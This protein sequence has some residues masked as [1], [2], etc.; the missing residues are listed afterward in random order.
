PALHG[1]VFLAI[2]GQHQRLDKD[3][4]VIAL[5]QANGVDGAKLVQL[6]KSFTISGKVSQARQLVQTYGVDSVP[7]LVVQGSYA[8]DVSMGG[9]DAGTLRVL[10]GLIQKSRA[11]LGGKA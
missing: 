2:H 5:A 3:A 7:R 9:G 4:E 10:D 8:T 1:K 6:M 11:K